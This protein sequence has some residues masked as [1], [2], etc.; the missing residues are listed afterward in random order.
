MTKLTKL[1]IAAI[2]ALLVAVVLGTAIGVSANTP[3]NVTKASISGLVSDIFE[4]KE[5]NSIS[6]VL[7]SGSAEIL[8]SLANDKTNAELEYKQFF[9]LDKNE[10]FI[11]KIK[12]TYND[13]TIDGSAYVGDDYMYLSV[14]KLYDTPIGLIRGNNEKLFSN[15]PFIFGSGTDYELPEATSDA[16]TAFLRYLD[17]KKVNEE[18]EKDAEKLFERYT[19]LFFKSLNKNAEFDK[20]NE[21]LMINGESINARV[22]E[23]RVNVECIVK[24]ANELYEELKKDEKVEELIKKYAALVE[25]YVKDTSLEDML[26]EDNESFV[27]KVLEV[28]KDTLDKAEDFIDNLENE[29]ELR[30]DEGNDLD[31]EFVIELATKRSSPTLLAMSVSA[32]DDEEKTEL[33][34]LEIGKDGIAKTDSFS[35]VLMEGEA[36]IKFE[37][38][39]DSK[40]AY[41]A[42]LSV[43]EGK[44][45]LAE[46]FVNI[47]KKEGS[48]SVGFKSDGETFTL[49][50]DYEK[51]GKKHTFKLKD[52]TLKDNEGNKQS[53]LKELLEDMGENAKFDLTLIINENEKPKPVSEKKIL[54]VLELDVEEL[55]KIKEAAEKLSEEAEDDIKDLIPDLTPIRLPVVYPGTEY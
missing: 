49:S 22:I 19:K 29:L 21:E 11:E 18:L 33:M 6:N 3:E 30:L 48:F 23:I 28:Y 8:L 36:K 55:N 26:T 31:G 41:E 51:S 54:S 15:S 24:I 7:K 25:Q 40:N 44:E 5:F 27:N 4:R 37:V 52:L 32:K 34:K 35:L 9:G 14:P 17:D 39:E 43:F 38:D 13:F 12:L 10:S 50:G 47:E 42:E 16:V 46:V 45:K 53:L 2:A 20:T 1:I